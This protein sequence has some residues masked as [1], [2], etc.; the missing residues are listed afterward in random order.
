METVDTLDYEDGELLFHHLAVTL[1]LPRGRRDGEIRA[2][3]QIRGIL[4]CLP[5]RPCRGVDSRLVDCSNH[6]SIE[7][8]YV[9]VYY[10]ESD[11]F[12]VPTP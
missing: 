8:T 4:P 2:H 7:S 10:R 5:D 11:S 12:H 3:T 9:Q 6:T 1:S